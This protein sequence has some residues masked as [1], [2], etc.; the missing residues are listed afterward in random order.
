MPSPEP[1]DDGRTPADVL[2]AYLGEMH[3]LEVWAATLLIDPNWGVAVANRADGIRAS[4][5]TDRARRTWAGTPVI[6]QPP[7]NNPD[8]TRIVEVRPTSR[9]RVR[10]LAAETDQN[11]T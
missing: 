5:C 10:I 7:A 3:D 9:N 6:A 4:Q 11:L 1:G 8:K 2:F